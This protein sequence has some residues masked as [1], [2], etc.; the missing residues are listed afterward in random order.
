[1]MRD[2]IMQPW[3]AFVAKTTVLLMI[4]LLAGCSMLRL[5][6]A[7]GENLLYWR[8]SEY[9]DLNDVQISRVRA[10]LERFFIWHRKTQL[11]KYAHSLLQVR[12]QLQH[13]TTA[14]HVLVEFAAF[15]QHLFSMIEYV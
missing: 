3:R 4:C 5:G 1:M 12:Q 11:K 10:D 6:Y 2:S 8:L 7:N 9:I 14:A 13:D 15:K